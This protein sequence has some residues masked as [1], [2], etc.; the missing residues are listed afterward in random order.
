MSS[1]FRNIYLSHTALAGCVSFSLFP[2]RVHCND[3]RLP[4]PP[5]N[6]KYFKIPQDAYV[7]KNSHSAIPYTKEVNDLR[8]RAYAESLGRFT[9][10]GYSFTDGKH[11]KE[12]GKYIVKEMHFHRVG[13]NSKFNEAL[14]VIDTCNKKFKKIDNPLPD[15]VQ[16]ICGWHQNYRYDWTKAPLQPPPPAPRPSESSASAAKPLVS[17]LRWNPSVLSF[18]TNLMPKAFQ[19][20]FGVA[21]EYYG[22][23]LY[24]VEGGRLKRKTR[25]VPALI[26]APPPSR[27][28]LSQSKHNIR[29]LAVIAPLQQAANLVLC[30]G[31]NQR[32]LGFRGWYHRPREILC[33]HSVKI[34]IAECYECKQPTTDKCRRFAAWDARILNRIPHSTRMRL[35]PYT[36]TWRAAVDAKLVQSL[37]FRAEGNTPAFLAKQTL[38]SHANDFVL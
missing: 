9:H 30:P 28:E 16:C 4:A 29:D 12:N 1:F 17:V 23:Q 24:D 36:F 35:Y 22:K 18:P 14:D 11:D 2:R 26:P 6:V 34:A 7:L 33:E 31:C 25:N 38:I 21:S 19:E 37:L 27:M 13:T 5:H 10:C 20:A 3:D 8:L 15:A 32:S